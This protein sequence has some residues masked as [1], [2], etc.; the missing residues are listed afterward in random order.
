MR[1]RKKQRHIYPLSHANALR[2]DLRSRREVILWRKRMTKGYRMMRWVLLAS[3]A[4]LAAIQA[5]CS[6]LL[7]DGV[8][9]GMGDRA[10]VNRDESSWFESMLYRI[11]DHR[12][13]TTRGISS[14]EGRMYYHDSKLGINTLVGN[15]G[16]GGAHTG[17]FRGYYAIDSNYIAI[18]ATVQSGLTGAQHER[19]YYSTDEGRTFGSFPLRG[20]GG[21]DEFVILRGPILYW[22]QADD[23]DRK[24]IYDAE[25]IDLS[26]EL[27]LKY[28]RLD[29]DITMDFSAKEI[30]L[31]IRS[32]S[33]STGMCQ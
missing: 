28:G 7:P 15:T 20:T 17:P 11:D 16:V 18:P 32:P 23:S 30:P 33:G 31:F 14:C 24:K 9:A 26:R 8:R 21:A 12:W 10:T 27:P 6:S 1:P 13:I 4:F 19:M 25:R 22:G 5:A 29:M 2:G 3:V